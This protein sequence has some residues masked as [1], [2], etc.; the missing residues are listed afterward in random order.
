MPTE[1]V[2][3]TVMGERGK[4]SLMHMSFYLLGVVFGGRIGWLLGQTYGGTLLAVL[5]T[6]LGA[7]LLS[8]AVGVIAYLLGYRAKGPT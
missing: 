4:P 2:K 8:S 7:V 6:V 1:G 5:L 3:E